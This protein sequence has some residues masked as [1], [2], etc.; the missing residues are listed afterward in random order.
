MK[1]R[2]IGSSRKTG[3]RMTLEFEAPSRAAAERKA[4][5][6]GMAVNRIETFGETGDEKPVP[7][8]RPGGHGLLLKMVAF[9]AIAAGAYY[10]LHQHRII[11]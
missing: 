4:Q 8:I 5:H 2:V 3:A 1:F 10:W 11:P 7:I 6:A 9:L